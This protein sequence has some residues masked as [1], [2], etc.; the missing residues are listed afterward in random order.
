[1]RSAT[2]G[3]AGT[4]SGDAVRAPTLAAAAG[5]VPPAGDATIPVIH[6]CH[7]WNISSRQI[8][9]SQPRPRR[10]KSSQAPRQAATSSKP[11]RPSAGR[12]ISAS[13]HGRKPRAGRRSARP[14]PGRRIPAWGARRGCEA[15]SGGVLRATAAC[16]CRPEPSPWPGNARTARSGDNPG[17]GSGP[18]ARRPCSHGQPSPGCRRSGRSRYP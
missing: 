3:V 7:A 15:R 14:R 8:T 10:A 9:G 17:A 13:A 12:L 1:M 5:P 11:L 4:R 16:R 2:P 18:R 6:S